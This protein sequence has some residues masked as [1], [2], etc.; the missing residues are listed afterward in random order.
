MIN[1]DLFVTDLSGQTEIVTGH[2]DLNIKRRVNGEYS[3]SFTLFKTKNNEHSYPLIQEESIV[4]YDGQSY[5]IKQLEE[6]SLGSKAVKTIKA[7]HIFF[8]LIDHYVYELLDEGEYELNTLLALVFEGSGY[9]YSISGTFQ[10]QYFEE[11]GQGNGLEL[12]NLLCNKYGAEI[13]VNNKH[14]TFK[15]RIGKRIDFQFRYKH[16][17]KTISKSVDTSNLSTVIRGYADKTEYGIYLVEAEYRSPLLS[18]YGERHAE[19][20]Y[21]DDLVFESSLLNRLKE[22][23]NDQP[24]ISYSLEFVELI[25][26]G[27]PDESFNLGDTV[28]TIWEPLGIDISTRIV[29]YTYY[30]HDP[31]KSV[32]TLANFKNNVTDIM[33]DFGKT[34]QNV[35]RI[36][37]D[38]GKVKFSAMDEQVKR[39]TEALLN[40]MTELEYPNEGGIIGRSKIDP[41]DYTVFNS[42]G[43]GIYRDGD[44][45]EAITTAGFNL[46]AGVIGQLTAKNIDTTGLISEQVEVKDPNRQTRLKLEAFGQLGSVIQLFDSNN[47]VTGRMFFFDTNINIIVGNAG[48]DGLRIYSNSLTFNGKEI[49]TRKYVDDAIASISN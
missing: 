33:A 6:R 2:K 43:F 41:S 25:K 48:L 14:V 27:F 32:V 22:S 10:K 34:K 30:P 46:S 24:D 35:D 26:Q 45:I 23:I 11:F 37:T 8:S 5:T 39:S 38:A 42:A 16:N 29:E 12:V 19:P 21:A 20:I 47:K 17:V 15:E 18:V 7:E 1:I 4:E 36:L 44:L 31:T 49:A 40:S 3:L 13:D 9:T 28:F